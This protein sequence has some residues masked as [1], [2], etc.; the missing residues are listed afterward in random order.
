MVAAL[1]QPMIAHKFG[2]RWPRDVILIVD[3]SM[4][5]ARKIR[6]ETVFNQELS[7]ATKLIELLET[8]DKVRVLLASPR[9][10][11]LNDSP[12][13]GTSPN[14]RELLARLRE[15]KPNAGAADLL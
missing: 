11:W 3:N 6:G 8:S 14:R 15:V 13:S 7:E 9:P 5:T 1:A 10:E 2:S 4:S 12:V